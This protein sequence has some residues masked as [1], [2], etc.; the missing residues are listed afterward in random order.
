[1]PLKKSPLVEQEE[2]EEEFKMHRATKSVVNLKEEIQRSERYDSSDMLID[3]LDF[4]PQRRVSENT[5]E[6]KILRDFYASL[7]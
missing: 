5:V 7:Y 1:M 4:C 2:L 6:K 3:P